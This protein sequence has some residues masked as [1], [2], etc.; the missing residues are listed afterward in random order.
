MMRYVILGLL[1]DRRARH[2]YALMKEY[3]EKS[4][5]AVSVGNVYRELQRLRADGLVQTGENPPGA[6]PRRLPYAISELGMR[7][8]DRWLER[9]GGGGVDTPDDEYSMRAFFGW[10]TAGDA[11]QRVLADWG[12]ELRSHARVLSRALERMVPNGEA[13]SHSTFSLWLDRRLRHLAIDLE[14]VET[15]R[16][17][18]ESVR[19]DRPGAPVK[20]SGAV[21]RAPA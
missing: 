16:A 17:A 1:R 11:G 21:R 8:F 18:R 13:R 14:F 5:R 7:E 3:R 20:K 9:R 19:V 12:E 4:G 15:L 6:D 10:Q 2:G